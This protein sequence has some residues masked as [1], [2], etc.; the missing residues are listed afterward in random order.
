MR[1]ATDVPF[2]VRIHIHQ[3]KESLTQKTRGRIYSELLEMLHDPGSCFCPLEDLIRDEVV[4][5]AHAEY[6][7]YAAMVWRA[8]HDV[9]P[10]LVGWLRFH[11]KSDEKTPRAQEIKKSFPEKESF[12]W[13][14]S[15]R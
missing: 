13:P 4:F 12:N 11:A 2:A 5:F 15:A 6:P 8:I 10:D 9:S 3:F 1:K 14:V 7:V